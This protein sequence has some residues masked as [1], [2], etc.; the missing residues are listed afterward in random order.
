MIIIYLYYATVAATPYVRVSILGTVKIF[1]KKNEKCNGFFLEEKQWQITVV[2]AK[3]RLCSLGYDK[4]YRKEP[5]NKVTKLL[6]NYGMNMS[7]P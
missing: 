5:L 3:G 6:I 7:I 2:V 4:V 1:R